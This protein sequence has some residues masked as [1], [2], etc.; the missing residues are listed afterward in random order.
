[1]DLYTAKGVSA[2]HFKVFRFHF[3]AQ[4]FITTDLLT[5]FCP[6]E[7]DAADRGELD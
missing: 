5:F 4:R 1:M 7:F 6:A 2:E 3:R